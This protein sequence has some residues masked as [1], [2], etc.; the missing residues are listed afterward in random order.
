MTQKRHLAD[1]VWPNFPKRCGELEAHFME[2]DEAMDWSR[3]KNKLNLAPA[4]I[5]NLRDGVPVLE[6]SARK[7][8]LKINVIRKSFDLPPLE[9][10]KELRQVVS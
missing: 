6:A 4:T 1:F 7:A 8:F 3:W 9:E 5:R 10:K 2:H